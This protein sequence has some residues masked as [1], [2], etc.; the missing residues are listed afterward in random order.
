MK[1]KKEITT[2]Q[3]IKNCLF[4]VREVF[5]FSPG[6]VIA[7]FLILILLECIST[8]QSTYYIKFL[9]EAIEEHKPFAHIAVLVAVFVVLQLIANGLD[10][11][12]YGYVCDNVWSRFEQKF[13]KKVF[14]KAGNVEL[15]CY[16]DADFYNKYTQAMDGTATRLMKVESH[17]LQ[18]F[19]TLVRVVLMMAIMIA[20]DPGVGVFLIFPLIGNFVFGKWLNDLEQKRYKENTRNDRIIEYVMRTMHLQ[21][22][23]KE[24]RITDIFPLMQKKHRRAVGEKCRVFDKYAGKNGFIY[25]VKVQFTYTFIFEG[26]LVYCSYRALVSG[27]IDLAEMTMLTTIMTSA[28]WGIIYLFNAVMEIHK[29]GIYIQNARD[30]LRYEEKIPEDGDGIPA[31]SEI[32]TVE[33]RNVSFIYHGEEKETLRNISFKIEKGKTVA[34][35]GLNGAGKCTLI[36]LLLRLYDPDSGEILLN[37]VNIK[38][39]ELKGYRK[40][41]SAAFQ[42]HQVVAMSVLDNIT[43]GAEK[44][45]AEERAACFLKKVGL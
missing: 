24:M 32:D 40:L 18:A 14:R 36:K 23:A 33:F 15:A 44:E 39:Y 19:A 7:N 25:W 9:I 20:I 6:F 31:P 8:I 22:F 1:K 3:V 5:K 10:W 26:I 27:T 29:E 12:F 38:E 11:I 37:G 34:L 17:A 4:A 43:M 30:F 42:D 21:Q 13:N 45:N 35:V 2:S 28:A 16:E 41:F